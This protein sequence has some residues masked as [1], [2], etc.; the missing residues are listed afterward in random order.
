MELSNQDLDRARSIAN[1]HGPSGDGDLESAAMAG[2]LEAATAFDGRGSWEGFSAQR[3]K[4][5]VRDHLRLTKAI[6]MDEVPAV[7]EGVTEIPSEIDN[8]LALLDPAV[9]HR[10]RAGDIDRRR[11]E[12]REALEA[13]RSAIGL[14][15]AAQGQLA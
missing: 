12:D 1:Q 6:P 5:R 9:A 8:A 15:G 7:T 13:I 3:V 2:L 14:S 11:K 4:W 10:F